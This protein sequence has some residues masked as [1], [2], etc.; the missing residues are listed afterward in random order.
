[1]SKWTIAI[2]AAL[3]VSV[4]APSAQ[5]ALVNGDFETTE[6]IVTGWWPTTFGD[7]VGDPASFVGTDKGISPQ[8]GSQMIRFD[9]ASYLGPGAGTTESQLGQLVDIT[10]AQGDG[11]HTANFSGWFNRVSGN[12]QTDTEFRLE[13]YAMQGNPANSTNM[14][15]NR[16]YLDMTDN[17]FQAAAN[18]WQQ[19]S[20]SML[21][22]SGTD[23]LLVFAVAVENVH[24][25]A[26]FP[27]YHGHYGDNFQLNISEPI[28]DD[29]EPGDD[30]DDT[31]RAELV[32]DAASGEVTLE[33]LTGHMITQFT[34]LSPDKFLGGTTFPNPPGNNLDLDNVISYTDLTATGWNGIISLGEILDSGYLKQELIDDILTSA[35]FYVE[36]TNG[37]WNFEIDVINEIPEPLTMSL[38]A[39][40]GL[41]VLLRRRKK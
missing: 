31:P 37:P 23:F 40:G 36:G 29:D 25:D 39:T 21:I 19:L 9:A 30:D 4:C 24:N 17:T 5:A 15:V 26:S 35:T 7:W 33:S 6:G 3:A 12:A 1:M 27:E 22:P 41:A 16:T 38:L 2:V 32:Y 34:L 18:N 28:G 10:P 8:S 11:T 13:M 20:T 14:R